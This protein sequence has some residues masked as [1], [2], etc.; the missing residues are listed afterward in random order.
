MNRSFTVL[1]VTASVLAVVTPPSQAFETRSTPAFAGATR[2]ALALGTHVVV[3]WNDLGMHCMNQYHLNFSVLPPYNN[4]RA[5]V[6]QRGDIST[7][8]RIATL[9]VNVTYSIPG[10][11]YS[12]GKTDFWTY[13][14]ALFG[15]PLAPNVGLTG[16]G[17]TGLCDCFH[18]W[19]QWWQDGRLYR[20][21]S[22]GS[23]VWRLRH[24]QWHLHVSLYDGAR[25]GPA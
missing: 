7:L 19:G 22:P 24:H 8:P 6:I 2:D 16:R 12:V 10:N 20:A 13:A 15:L 18:Q 17:L 25:I 1:F 23:R 9:G 5:Q 3:A 11:T 4:L 21:I 14:P